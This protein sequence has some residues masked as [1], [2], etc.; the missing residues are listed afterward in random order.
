[1]KIILVLF[2]VLLN[3]LSPSIT[4]VLQGTPPTSC[5]TCRLTST[6][7]SDNY[8]LL[9]LQT[10][11]KNPVVFKLSVPL[12]LHVHLSSYCCPFHYIFLHP[13]SLQFSC[14]THINLAILTFSLMTGDHT[15]GVKLDLFC[16]SKNYSLLEILWKWS[17]S[18]VLML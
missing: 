10:V 16:K 18:C 15:P 7:I 14:C 2:L 3:S 4:V 1:M 9:Y 11:N 17:L 5:F 12:F 6:L 13:I 8:S